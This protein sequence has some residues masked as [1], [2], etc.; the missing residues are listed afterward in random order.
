MTHTS[1]PRRVLDVPEAAP[2]SELPASPAVVA[3]PFVFVGSTSA[4]NWTDGLPEGARPRPGL[5]YSD[6]NPVL[7][8]TREI[9][10]KLDAALQAGGSSFEETVQINQWLASYHGDV[11]RDGP[12]RDQHALFWE[13]WR[14]IIVPCLD[15][16]N[17]FILDQRPASCAMP[18]D[19]LLCSDSTV[20]VQI[21]GLV[22]G[23][24]ITKR[25]YE[26]DVH[27]PLGGY[28]IGMESGPFLFT[29]GF[30]PTNFVTG[31]ADGVA[32]PDH[33]WYGNR[34][35]NEV[36]ETLRQLKVTVEAGN[37]RW[38][39]TVKAT[40]YVTPLALRNLPAI[41]AAFQ[42]FWPE[43]PPARAIVP[44]TGIGGLNDGNIE[45]YLTVARPEFGG[46]KT[47]IHTD[48]A[49]PALGYAPQAVK[50]GPLLYLSTV[51]GRTPDGA[52]P[53]H[54]VNDRTF[55]FFGRSVREEVRLIQENINFI[56]EAAGTSIDQA[57]KTELYF[58]DF[59]DLSAALPVW[60]DAFTDGYPASGFFEG[61]PHLNEV[62]G[63]RLTVD[64]VVACPD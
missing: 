31:A 20:E 22:E 45:I 7:L 17:E 11:E 41:D 52:P 10:R 12:E 5:P 54:A 50:S 49:L 27:M 48:K 40:V 13:K 25:A 8:E 35:Y 36:A 55:P 37:G 28:S 6:G 19:R 33:I 21:V 4:S 53:S 15:A 39:D 9:Y 64:M 14:S 58:N 43:N 23:C 34:T 38:E 1:F 59:A 30:I 24:G 46:E 16:R 42:R 51:Q 44:V 57:V 29:A 61:F 47:P 26:H 18:V 32:V 56:C 60:A 3:G 62:P 2:P 63:C